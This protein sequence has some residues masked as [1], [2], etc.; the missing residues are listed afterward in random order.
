MDHHRRDT[1]LAE[2]NAVSAPPLPPY[3]Y[4]MIEEYCDV[5]HWRDLGL[6]V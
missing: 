6:T 2:L 5:P 1:E 4:G 3:P